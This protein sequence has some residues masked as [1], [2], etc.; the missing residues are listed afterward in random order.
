MCSH[1]MPSAHDRPMSVPESRKVGLRDVAQ[2]A[3]VSKSIA[4]RV[5]N[6]DP[7]VSVREETRARI[8]ASAAELAYRPDPV[9]K[10]LARPRTRALAL[11]VPAFSNPA[12]T[13]LIE[14]AYRQAWNR[15]F[16]LLTAEDHEEG[17]ANAAFTEL[18]Q[19]GRIDG[20]LIASAMPAQALIDALER[21]WVPHVF[22]NR[23]IPGRVSNIVLEVEA[24]GRLACDFLT[25]LGHGHLGHVG[26]PETIEAALRRE[27]AFIAAVT[28]RGLPSPTVV[29]AAFS[30]ADG[31]RAARELL[32]TD[33]AVT[34]IFVSSF[35]QA[36][37]VLRA[38]HQLGRRVPEDLS[39]VSYEDVPLAAYL[40][41][42]LTTIAMP[43]AELGARA[44]DELIEQ[45]S[46]ETPRLHTVHAAPRIVERG[47]TGRL[48]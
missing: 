14:G 19:A 34:A 32:T 12:Y 33:P 9:A 16:I 23:S 47:S 7:T 4:S 44:V 36:A 3:G 28:E 45:I 42:P 25:D 1:A 31:E 26:G 37:G 24:A 48:S 18:V 13:P 17:Q 30:E 40:N 46:G 10:A 41:P 6:N 29:R 22:V 20:L 39:V 38:A 5:L 27:D 15:G 11:L 43:I 21:D 8:L 35:L 2:H